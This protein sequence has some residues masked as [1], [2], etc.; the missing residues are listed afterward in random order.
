MKGKRETGAGLGSQGGRGGE[1]VQCGTLPRRGG[2]VERAGPVQ[3]ELGGA[4]LRRDGL[5]GH[6]AGVVPDRVGVGQ[7]EAA[8]AGPAV[9]P[10]EVV[11]VADEDALELGLVL[12]AGGAG[13]ARFGQDAAGGQA[14]DGGVGDRLAL[15]QVTAVTGDLGQRGQPARLVEGQRVMGWREALNELDSAYPG[16]LR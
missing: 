4:G 15:S 5:G 16:R 2:L 12:V 6:V 14:A 10:P 9:V 3:A 7:D 8:V 1:E 13:L 11:Q